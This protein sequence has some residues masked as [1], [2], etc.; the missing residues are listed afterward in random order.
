MT[1]PDDTRGDRTGAGALRDKTI[2]DIENAIS[3]ALSTLAERHWRSRSRVSTSATPVLNGEIAFERRQ[4]PTSGRVKS[5]CTP[6]I[7][8]HRMQGHARR[9]TAL[10]PG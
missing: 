2:T 3:E 8:I 1:A 10:C 5:S 9:H 7:R 6:T 4:R